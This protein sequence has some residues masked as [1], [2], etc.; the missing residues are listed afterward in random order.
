MSNA[1][2]TNFKTKSKKNYE[3][4]YEKYSQF[5]TVVHDNRLGTGNTNAKRKGKKSEILCKV[6]N[7]PEFCTF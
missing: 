1:I 4:I 6:E 5:V 3:I 7:H 2:K